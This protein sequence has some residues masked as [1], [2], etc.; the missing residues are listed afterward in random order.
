MKTYAFSDIHGNYILWKK[1][2]NYCQPDDI[3]IFLGDAIDRGNDGIK[4]MQEMFLDP[5]II[6]LKGNHEDLFLSYIKNLPLAYKQDFNLIVDN[7]SLKTLKSFERL[8]PEEQLELISNLKKTYIK[9]L[10][11]NKDNKKI[12]LSHSGYD[13]KDLLKEDE[14]T[15]IWNRD[16][17]KTNIWDEK[18]YPDSYIVHGHTPVQILRPDNAEVRIYRYCNQHKID[19][20]LACFV[21]NKIALLDLDNLKPIYFTTDQAISA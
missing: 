4:I 18:T 8:S 6:Y 14:P 17:L 3:I 12:Y 11:I 1:I 7:Q 10:Y 5:R 19:I 15:F 9:Y 13:I 16:H 21:S 2:Q 20:D